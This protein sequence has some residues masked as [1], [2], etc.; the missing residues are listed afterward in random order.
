MT[1]LSPEI[2]KNIIHSLRPGMA[3]SMKELTG[4]VRSIVNYAERRKD[5]LEAIDKSEEQGGFLNAL[6]RFRHSAFLALDG[7]QMR[8]RFNITLHNTNFEKIDQL[9]Q[10]DLLSQSSR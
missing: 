6:T 10:D 9:V 1:K 3:D 8:F 7:S 2:R 4:L 5:H